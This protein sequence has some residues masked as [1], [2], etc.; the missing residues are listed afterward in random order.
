M[1]NQIIRDILA[2]RYSMT[3]ENT[4]SLNDMLRR[5]INCISE[6]FPML[7]TGSVITEKNKTRYIAEVAEGHV[8]IKIKEVFYNSPPSSNVFNDSDIPMEGLPYGSSLSQRFTDMFEHETRRRLKPVDARVV[9]T[10]QFDLIPTPQDVRTI[11][12]EYE[13]YRTLEEVPQILE[14][15]LFALILYYSND[16][17]YQRKRKEN[18]GT[19]F[20][21]NRRGETKDRSADVKTDVESRKIELKLIKDDIKA[22]VMKLG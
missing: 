5:A 14:E 1:D 2:D 7:E 22:K 9:N 12:F 17:I 6:L 8:L 21:F 4:P 20:E 18:N 19:I 16:E 11:Y 13:R 3:E 10:N 15:E